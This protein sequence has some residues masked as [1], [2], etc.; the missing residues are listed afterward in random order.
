MKVVV[1]FAL[2][3]IMNLMVNAWLVSMAVTNAHFQEMF[4]LA[5]TVVST[6]KMEDV[7]KI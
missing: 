7:C 2:M 3:V 1:P 4:A 5:V 6:Y